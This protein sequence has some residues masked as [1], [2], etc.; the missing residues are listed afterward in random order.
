MTKTN[1]VKVVNLSGEPI[2]PKDWSKGAKQ[3]ALRIADWLN[4]Q[5]A[6]VAIST[7]HDGVV[8]LDYAYKGKLWP[9]I[10]IE[11]EE[12]AIWPRGTDLELMM[13]FLSIGDDHD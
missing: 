11:R 5:G 1:K 9:T 4:K 6:Q 3:Q 13:K 12:H 7:T 10:R 2:N 8:L